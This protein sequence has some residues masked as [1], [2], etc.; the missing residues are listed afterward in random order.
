MVRQE[1]VER[2]GG[3]DQ[4]GRRGS[5]AAT[6]PT[7]LLRDA[8]DGPR[9]PDEQRR[10]Q[11]ADVDAQFEGVGGND[12]FDRTVAQP[13]FD[14]PSRRLRQSTILTTHRNSTSIRPSL[15]WRTRSRK[16]SASQ[17]IRKYAP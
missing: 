16:T 11:P 13:F 5:F 8:C 15:L 6:G 3:G 12:K 4:H 7:R 9:I 17:A 2:T 14:L 1:L 10:A